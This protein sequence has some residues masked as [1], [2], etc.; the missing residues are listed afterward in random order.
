M[1]PLDAES[2]PLQPRIAMLLLGEYDPPITAPLKTRFAVDTETAVKK[3]SFCLQESS[4]TKCSCG[5]KTAHWEIKFLKGGPR[6]TRW[7]VSDLSKIFFFWANNA[8]DRFEVLRVPYATYILIKK[9]C[10]WQKYTFPLAIMIMFIR[11]VK[12]EVL[13]LACSVALFVFIRNKKFKEFT[14]LMS[15]RINWA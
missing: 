4:L 15:A 10:C 3:L 5:V 8:I 13:L 1:A 14:F 12:V 9:N 7:K 2:S 11:R 6:V